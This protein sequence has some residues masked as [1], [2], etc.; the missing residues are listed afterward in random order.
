MARLLRAIASGANIE[1]VFDSIANIVCERCRPGA[2]GGDRERFADG[3][4]NGIGRC[5]VATSVKCSSSRSTVSSTRSV[6]GYPAR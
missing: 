5:T 2:F 3:Y 4:R 6:L 1:Q